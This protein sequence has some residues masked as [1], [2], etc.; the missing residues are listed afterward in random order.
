M[1]LREHDRGMITRRTNF[2]CLSPGASDNTD[3]GA[4]QQSDC[5]LIADSARSC[6]IAEV[7]LLPRLT[8]SRSHKPVVTP[9][10]KEVSDPQ[11]T[12]ETQGNTFILDAGIRNTVS[13]K[14]RVDKAEHTHTDTQT[15][16]H[17][18]YTRD[19]RIS[20]NSL[21]I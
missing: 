1:L 5:G 18:F 13:N 10:N 4:Y 20:T 8:R 7:A 9:E 17:G 2:R 19:T 11:R 6:A 21:F 12:N 16:R 14:R 3:T 15:D